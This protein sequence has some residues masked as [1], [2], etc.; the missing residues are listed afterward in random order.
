MTTCFYL[1]QHGNHKG[2][3]H[4][5]GES[6]RGEGQQLV[7]PGDVPGL[8]HDAVHGAQVAQVTGGRQAGAKRITH[9]I[10]T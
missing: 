4:Q 3:Q 5:Q 10:N 1:E 6:G 2:G 8:G 7:A 9:F